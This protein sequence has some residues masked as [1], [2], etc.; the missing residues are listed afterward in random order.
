MTLQAPAHMRKLQI[1]FDVAKQHSSIPSHHVPIGPR[2]SHTTQRI[3]IFPRHVP[4]RAH[5]HVTGSTLVQASQPATLC[6]TPRVGKRRAPTVK[7]DGRAQMASAAQRNAT[8]RP[9]RTR[10]KASSSKRMPCTRR[11]RACLPP[12]RRPSCCVTSPRSSLLFPDVAS[13]SEKGRVR[14]WTPC[15]NMARGSRGPA[16]WV[17]QAGRWDGMGQRLSRGQVG[18]D[19]RME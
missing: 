3:Q 2:P 8:Q 13:A 4:H 1:T 14:A 18:G 5:D 19:C 10:S 15:Q 11:L 16:R 7:K 12:F 17:W 6:E 9:S